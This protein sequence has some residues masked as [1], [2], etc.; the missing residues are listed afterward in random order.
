MTFGWVN[1]VPESDFTLVVVKPPLGIIIIINADADFNIMSRL[2]P[3]DT[4]TKCVP[5]PSLSIII[6]QLIKCRGWNCD[7]VRM[8]YLIQ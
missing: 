4:L 6:F 5:A 1:P 2:G 7:M 3:L 8:Y